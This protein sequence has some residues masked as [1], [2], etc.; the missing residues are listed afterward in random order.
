MS[1][2]KLALLVSG[3]ALALLVACTNSAGSSDQPPT[4]P[5][6]ASTPVVAQTPPPIPTSEPASARTAPDD[7]EVAQGEL[8]SYTRRGWNTDFTR[9]SVS[10]DEI[11]PAGPPKVSRPSVDDPKFHKVADA[12]A[13]MKDDEPVLS[14]ELNGESRAYPLAIL[15][16]HEI[17]ND[18]VGGTPVVA[19]YCPLC[20]T[21]IVFY[22]T[23]DGETYDFGVTGNL[24]FSDLL[25]WD[26]QTESWW[27]QITGEAIVGELTGKK[28]TFIP[29]SVVSWREFRETFPQGRLLSR[30]TGFDFDYDA[31]RYAGY[32]SAG[33]YPYLLKRAPDLRMRSM[34]R[35]VGVTIGDQA[36]AYPFSLLEERPVFNDSVNGMDLVVFFSEGA[37]SPFPGPENT[38]KAVVGSAAVYEARLDG[39]KLT[40]RLVV[41]HH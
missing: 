12:P 32:D 28:L 37:L 17:V 19:T 2:G 4:A 1:Y 16:R 15:V 34:E 22:R 5:V 8:P 25:M 3:A 21:A 35:V 11:I 29:A 23:V 13:Y 20:N 36:V 41:Q 26:R 18:E 24:R 27:Q 9:H 10:Y 33:S 31:P 39:A 6:V 40:F 30:E 38:D 7:Q 14:L